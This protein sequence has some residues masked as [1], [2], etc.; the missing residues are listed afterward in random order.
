MSFERKDHLRDTDW[1]FVPRL[2]PEHV[3][4]AF[5]I[6]SLLDDRKQQGGQLK[7]PHSGNQA[8]RFRQAMEDRNRYIIENGQPDAVSHAC[9]K[10]LRIYETDRDNI[11]QY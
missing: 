5:V 8:G 3:W 6:Y 4:D 1:Q 10:C 2:S 11:R 7:V 9:D